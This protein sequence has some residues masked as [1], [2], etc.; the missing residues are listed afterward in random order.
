MA[1]AV[2]GDDDA[3]LSTNCGLGPPLI[4]PSTAFPLREFMC[5][6]LPRTT[7]GE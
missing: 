7:S 4:V 3:K 5:I 6:N 1:R 2:N